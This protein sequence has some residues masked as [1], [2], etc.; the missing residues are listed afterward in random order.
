MMTVAHDPPE[1]GLFHLV[2]TK[3]SHYDDEGYPIQ[4]IRS[5]ISSNTLGLPE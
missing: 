5:A 1:A 3:P 4:W 2:M